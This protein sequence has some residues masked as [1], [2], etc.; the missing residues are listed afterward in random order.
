MG[1]YS[2]QDSFFPLLQ[3]YCYIPLLVFFQAMKGKIEKKY[4]EY[5]VIHPWI[6]YKVVD[7]TPIILGKV[8]D[9]FVGLIDED[10]LGAFINNLKQ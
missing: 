8:V 7:S 6:H 10:K 1:V 3:N 9:R 5:T 4:T 2:A